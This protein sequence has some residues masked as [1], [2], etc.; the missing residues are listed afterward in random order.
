MRRGR[1]MRAVSTFRRRDGSV[2]LLRPI[3]IV[4][5]KAKRVDRRRAEVLEA[6]GELE[7]VTEGIGHAATPICPVTIEA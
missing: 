1:G 5:G 2:P 7:G 3:A 4:V 6:D